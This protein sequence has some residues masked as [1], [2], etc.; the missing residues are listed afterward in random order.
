L[1][2][3]SQKSHTAAAVKYALGRWEALTRYAEDGGLE[4]DNN[5]ACA[6]SGISGGMPTSGLCRALSPPIYSERE[7]A[8]LI[9]AE[10]A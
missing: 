1:T 7:L 3:L 5:A 4:I 9:V 8:A 2:K 6:A 10:A